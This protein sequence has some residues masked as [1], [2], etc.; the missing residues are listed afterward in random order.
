MAWLTKEHLACIPCFIG[1]PI[2]GRRNVTK[3]GHPPVAHPLTSVS[4]PTRS[5]IYFTMPS[6]TS[7]AVTLLAATPAVFAGKR[8]LAYPWCKFGLHH[9][10]MIKRLTI[11]ADNENTNIDPGKLAGSQVNWMYNWETWRPAR[12]TYATLRLISPAQ[13]LTLLTAT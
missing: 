2:K 13:V 5:P 7:V 1:L 6:L 4:F 11:L 9:S 8:G 3:G 10:S 12:T